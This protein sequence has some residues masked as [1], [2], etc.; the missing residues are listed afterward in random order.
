M[1]SF[2]LHITILYVYNKHIKKNLERE[3]ERKKKKKDDRR[4]V[5]ARSIEKECLLNGL[6]DRKWIWDI[7]NFLNCLHGIFVFFGTGCRIISSI[8]KGCVRSQKVRGSSWN[9]QGKMTK[10]CI[11]IFVVENTGQVRTEIKVGRSIW[12]IAWSPSIYY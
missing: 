9:Y 2:T 8:R 6:C 10:S 3:R 11:P 4:I 7:N 5:F 12:I 1:R